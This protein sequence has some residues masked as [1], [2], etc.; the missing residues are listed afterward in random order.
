[1]GDS[2]GDVVIDKELFQNRLTS[3][4]SEW[5]NDKRNNDALFG[6]A[7]SIAI[8]FGKTDETVGFQKNNAFQVRSLT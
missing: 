8:V 3:F 6:G 4:I 7:T 2:G 5:K 1:M